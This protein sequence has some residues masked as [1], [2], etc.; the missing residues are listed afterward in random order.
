MLAFLRW[1]FSAN[2]R[3]SQYLALAPVALYQT[4]LHPCNMPL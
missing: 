1:W 2:A 3:V 4:E